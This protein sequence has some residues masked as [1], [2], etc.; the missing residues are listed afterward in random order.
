M[1]NKQGKFGRS[2][3][4]VTALLLVTAATLAL[5]ACGKSSNSGKT[6]QVLKLSTPSELATLDNSKASESVSLTQLY[7]TGEGLYFFIRFSW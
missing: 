3:K 7:H 5:A 6:Q 1:F 4:R 2:F